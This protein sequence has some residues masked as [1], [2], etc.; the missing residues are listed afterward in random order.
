MSIK[1][2][3]EQ[4][5]SENPKEKKLGRLLY[6]QDVTEEDSW[7]I[8]YVNE[9]RIH[10]NYSLSLIGTSLFFTGVNYSMFRMNSFWFQTAF[11]CSMTFV[12]HLSIRRK[13]NLHFEERVNP[14]FE[15][16]SVK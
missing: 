13:L 6:C 1:A 12:S 8:N 11:I 5:K 16:Y 3:R 2:R 14:Y 4:Q 9:E 7:L 10:F 15:K